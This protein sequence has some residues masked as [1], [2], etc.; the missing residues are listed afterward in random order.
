MGAAHPLLLVLED[1]HDADRGALD[2]LVYLAR[3]LARTPLMIIG[4]YRDVEVDRAHPLAASLAEL[5]RVSQFERVHL[6]E[7]SVSNVQRL[8]VAST[9]QAVPRPLAELVHHRSGGNALFVHELLRF[10]VSE[11][12]V[13]R[14]DGALRRV[15]ESDL[16]GQ[17][18]EGL[19]DVV[20]K[21]LS[22]LSPETNQVLSLASVIGREFS[23]EVLR[24]VHARPE[25]D[26]EDALEE[27]VGAAIL[28]ERSA[29]AATITYRFTHAFFQQTLYD[30]ILAPRRMRQHQQVARALEDVHARRSDST[31]HQD[32]L[33]PGR[34]RGRRPLAL[35]KR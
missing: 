23:L 8:L 21:R 18:P 30:E 12:L 27:A 32:L 14:R 10:L 17:M 6:G 13:E 35:A 16:T 20:G 26:L 29:R 33:Q 34:P 1:L 22:R 19:R 4:T 24:R 3:H 15:G 2:L 11:G 9:H 5:R 28:E 31:F 7:L 25:E